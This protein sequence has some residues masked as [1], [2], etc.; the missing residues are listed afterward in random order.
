MTSRNESPRANVERQ[1]VF[2]Y[3]LIKATAPD[4][5][6][7]VAPNRNKM[8][9]CCMGY[10]KNRAI[11]ITR[12][13]FAKFFAGVIVILAVGCLT[14][15]LS[16]CG[17]VLAQANSSS[18]GS[19]VSQLSFTGISSIDNVSGVSVRLNWTNVT[20][21]FGYNVFN[22][23]SG[24]PVLIAFVLAPATNYTVTGLSA[25]TA[26]K[27]RVRLVDSEG[28]SDANTNDQ[29]VTTAS[30]SA[31]WNGWTFINA[32][33]PKVPSPQGSDLSSVPASVTLSWSAMTPSSGSISS[34]NIY[35][36]TTSG[37]ESYGS[38]L[39]T[40]I[41]TASMSYTDST[42]S[43]NTTYYYTVAPVVSGSTIVP[44]AAADLEVKV[45]VPP[46]N[47]VLLN[48]W[49]ANIEACG[50]MGKTTDRT[51]NYR[52]TVATGA[53]APP[54]TGDSGYVDLGQSYFIDAQDQGC[55]YTDTN[56]CTDPT[57]NGG[58]ASPCIGIE[59]TPS[60]TVTAANGAI[61]YDR[62]TGYCYINTSAVS[63]TTWTDANSAT[64]TEL[65]TM[66]SN[67]PGL[68]PFVNIDQPNSQYVCNGQTVS[69]FAGTKKLL[70]HREQILVS[71]WSTSLTNAEI[72]TLENGSNLDTTHDCNA[73]YASPQGNTVTNISGTD[74]TI[75]Y[76][77]NVIP[78]ALD[79]L[80]W[81]LDSNCSTSGTADGRSV[82]TGSNATSSCVSVFGAQDMAGNVWQWSSDQL[83]CNGT[84]CAGVPASSNTVDNTNDDWN[85]LN[86]NGTQGP[87]SNNY[88]GSLAG[89]Q[90]PDGI[91]IASAGFTGDG[92]ITPTPAAEDN[93]YFWINIGAGN[94]GSIAGGSWSYGSH[95]GRFALD[96]YSSPTSTGDD[97]GF[98]CAL[99][100]GN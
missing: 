70:S 13:P 95:G 55:N 65:A 28:L 100:A 19:G 16:G 99:P 51:N 89:V 7:D 10:L 53:N 66:G 48:R 45:M 52:C 74:P 57:V 2:K 61:Y 78:T 43:A 34:Y 88:F 72:Q 94:Y 56:S 58:A 49:A 71:P 22:V 18:K 37:T 98:R 31:T 59:S 30:I 15:L 26:Y 42:V 92:F 27:F 96:L 8:D 64:Q 11:R 79:T 63:G 81:C 82:R 4:V 80:P 23:T 9:V 54:G 20:G 14:G 83:T 6:I 46:D 91:P 24:S 17:A 35:R 3:N 32:L 76:D 86:F 47:M 97:I 29:S 68:P 44:S 1:S 73:N 41:T 36:V 84:T 25:T 21:A 50:W 5:R 67:A 90:Y 40:G 77:N 38:P 60:A 85:G 39:A 33:G 75:A 87:T 69:G 62:Q 12:A 93:D